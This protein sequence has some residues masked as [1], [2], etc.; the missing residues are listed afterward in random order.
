MNKIENYLK[1][2][3]YDAFLSPG[4]L[5]PIPL[6]KFHNKSPSEINESE[7]FYFILEGS[8]DVFYPDKNGK[9]HLW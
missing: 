4:D 6:E 3:G 1:D 2:S 8:M 7:G 9:N 5:F